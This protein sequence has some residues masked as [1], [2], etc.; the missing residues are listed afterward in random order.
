MNEFQIP[1][2]FYPFAPV[3]HPHTLE[4]ERRNL[5]R[6]A[7]RL[8]LSPN[9]KAYL[10]LSRCQ[11]AHFIGRC[12]PSASLEDLELAVDFVTWFFLWDDQFDQRVGGEL[13]HPFWV[14]TQN[15]LALQVLDGES[16]NSDSSPLL[17]ALLK[18]REGLVARMPTS[19]FCRLVSHLSDYFNVTLQELEARRNGECPS[20]DS[21]ICMRLLT[22]GVFVVSPLIEMIE[23]AHL[24][25]HVWLSEQV[26]SLFQAANNV[27]GWSNDLF[28][29]A[30]D[31]QD[32]GHLNIVISLRHHQGLELQQA[33]TEAAEMHNSE[34]R[35]FLQ[36]ERELPG[37]GRDS[38]A[39]SRFLR[40]LR[41]WMRANLDWSILTGRYQP[42]TSD[43]LA[44]SADLDLASLRGCEACP[45]D[46]S[47]TRA[48]PSAALLGPLPPPQQGPHPS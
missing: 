45:P 17:W 12:H 1:E 43:S 13:A 7:K 20:V 27:M 11:F 48:A 34:V 6:W 37:F 24:P 10:K 30:N 22:S 21:Y 36:V 44:P 35:R 14:A 23:D 46:E 38:G 28:S 9:D 41:R 25:K 19:L 5:A 32:E 39:V 15:A 26:Q 40:G 29:L 2:L 8:G 33:V 42:D 3:L 4:A 47:I 16:P 31:L 18:L